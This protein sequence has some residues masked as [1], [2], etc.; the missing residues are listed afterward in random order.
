MATWL[1]RYSSAFQAFQSRSRSVTA[2][3]KAA[4]F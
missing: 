3:E 1:D 4:E 2:L